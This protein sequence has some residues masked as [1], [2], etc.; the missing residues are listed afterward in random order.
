M[1]QIEWTYQNIKFWESFRKSVKQFYLHKN[2]DADWKQLI[3]YCYVCCIY[4]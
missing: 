4:C 2:M 3:Y 1:E